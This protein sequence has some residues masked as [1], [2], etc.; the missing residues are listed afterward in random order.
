MQDVTFPMLTS[1]LGR[2]ARQWWDPTETHREP[3]WRNGVLPYNVNPAA[4]GLDR[5]LCL[6][7]WHGSACVT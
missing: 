5:R 3:S 6:N 4:D 2:T 1:G 7:E